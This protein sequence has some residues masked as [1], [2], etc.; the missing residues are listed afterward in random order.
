MTAQFSA[1]EIEDEGL[2]NLRE[3]ALAN[4]LFWAL[5]EGHAC[6]QSARQNAMDVSN[7]R[8]RITNAYTDVTFQNASKN[9]G[10]MINKFQI[11]YNRT[12]QAVITG[13]LVEII[14]GAAASEG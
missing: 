12:R 13:E 8:S 9:A 7:L 1:F 14:T 10:D 5:A 4:S 2:P 6:E 11:L 3:Y